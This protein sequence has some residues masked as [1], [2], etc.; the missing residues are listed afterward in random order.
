MQ[1]NFFSSFLA[2]Q[3]DHETDT[4]VSFPTPINHAECKTR[5]LRTGRKQIDS[6]ILH[7]FK[8]RCVSRV[9]ETAQSPSTDLTHQPS[10]SRTWNAAQSRTKRRYLTKPEQCVSAV[11]DVLAPVDSNC[12]WEELSKR[13]GNLRATGGKRLETLLKT[14]CHLFRN[15]FRQAA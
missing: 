2:L 7:N 12:F 3:V 10:P 8:K 14:L 5:L 9:P 15:N 4:D 1:F 13:K 6:W 11:P